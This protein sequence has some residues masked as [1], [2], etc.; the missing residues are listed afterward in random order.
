VLRSSQSGGGAFLCVSLFGWSF[1]LLANQA[2][3]VFSGYIYIACV[4]ILPVIFM[5]FNDSHLLAGCFT[6]SDF[7]SLIRLLFH[8]MANQAAEVFFG[9]KSTPG[10][11][12]TVTQ[13]VEAIRAR[14]DRV[15]RDANKVAA[16]LKARA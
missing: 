4:A 10:I 5:I 16:W 12:R 9:S 3:A 2:A 14:S 1:R 15:K 8:L 7:V 11:E 6:D 13:S